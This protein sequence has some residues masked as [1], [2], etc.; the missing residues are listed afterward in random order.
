MVRSHP[1]LHP[2]LK[3]RLVTVTDSSHPSSTHS[4]LK[5]K[6]RSYLFLAKQ[7]DQLIPSIRTCTV[8]LVRRFGSCGMGSIRMSRSGIFCG[9]NSSRYGITIYCYMVT[10]EVNP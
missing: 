4:D 3:H 9:M 8:R 5:L 6:F 7:A 2:N 10:N 1:N